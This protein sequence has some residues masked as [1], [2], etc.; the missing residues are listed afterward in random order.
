MDRISY[1]ELWR[2]HERRKERLVAF[3]RNRLKSQLESRGARG[4]QLIQAEEVLSPYTL[5]ISFARRF[6]TYK[7]AALLFRDPERLLRLLS[8][9][10]RPIQLIFSGKAHPHDIP[11]KNL[12]K[13]IVHFASQPEVRSKIV[14]LEN[15]DL[16]IAKHLVSGSDLWLNTPRRPQEASGTSGM[17]AVM[18]GVLNC[19][20][21]DGWWAEAYSPDYGWAIGNGEIYDDPEMQ[22]EIE[23]KALYDLLEREIVPLYYDRGRDGLPRGW[24][25]KMKRSMRELGKQFSCQ[26]MI[27]EYAENFYIPA[28]DNFESLVDSEFGRAKEDAGYIAK[29]RQH[30]PSVWISDITRDGQPAMN[31]GDTMRVRASVHLGELTP[32][33]VSVEAYYG[34]IGSTGTYDNPSRTEMKPDGEKN[35]AEHPYTVDVT[36]N[37]AGKQGVSVRVMPK[38][39]RLVHQFVP[40]I[41]R[42]A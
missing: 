29:L 15:Y 19:S 7:R 40:G 4:S 8:D 11:G 16:N 17:K 27:I 34:S 25:D 14:F 30:W 20:V 41:I 37:R 12:I 13:E 36:C 28:L 21:L 24:I 6:A 22:D 31:L 1:E 9:N 33:D 38:H 23:S 39:G 10:D 5:T 18:N 2:T 3:T 35:G 32:E 26:R 42:W